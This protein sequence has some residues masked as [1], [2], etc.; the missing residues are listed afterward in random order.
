MDMEM[1]SGNVRTAEDMEQSVNTGAS[2]QQKEV[3]EG[4]EGQ[5][6][7]KKAHNAGKRQASYDAISPHGDTISVSEAG[8]AANSVKSNKLVNE[9]T[10]DGI[11]IRKDTEESRQENDLSTINLSGYTET[12]LKQMYLDGDITRAEYEEEISSREMEK[13][14]A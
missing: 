1:I 11:V 5:K 4:A 2:Q 12:E 9:D 7:I 6:E 13:V 3:P 8:K 10:T 14:L